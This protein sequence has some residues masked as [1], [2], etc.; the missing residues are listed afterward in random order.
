[1]TVEFFFIPFGSA[2]LQVDF[3]VQGVCDCKSQTLIEAVNANRI[4]SPSICEMHNQNYSNVGKCKSLAA[5]ASTI[6]VT[7]I[8]Y[9]QNT[10]VKI[11][12]GVLRGFSLKLDIE[13]Q[14]IV[15]IA[16]IDSPIFQDNEDL[17]LHQ[18]QELRQVIS[19]FT[20]LT[21]FEHHLENFLNTEIFLN[22]LEKVSV[23]HVANLRIEIRSNEH[24]PPHFHVCG[25][26]ISASF[27]IEDGSLIAGKLTPTQSKKIQ[28][29]YKES[30]EKLVATWNRTRPDGCTVGLI[31]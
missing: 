11:Q 12:E 9:E 30:K 13:Q 1:M 17:K 18:A 25:Q 28:L 22:Q 8:I 24:P 20:L 5:F 26:G 29:W 6:E 14:R 23:D 31:R 19:S 10:I 4:D 15:D 2:I 27:S 21:E 7:A 3:I 16:M